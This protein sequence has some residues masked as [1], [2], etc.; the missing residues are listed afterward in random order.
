MPHDEYTRMTHE[1]H[2][3][4]EVARVS[5]FA[6]QGDEVF[7]LMS[8]FLM[9]LY[10]SIP[11]KY[12]NIYYTDKNFTHMINSFIETKQD[13]KDSGECTMKGR[14]FADAFLDE[15]GVQRDNKLKFLRVA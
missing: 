13:I 6:E 12:Q 10:N 3:E 15:I 4:W 1:I 8:E 7:I 2:K 14:E 5:T 11:A 9:S